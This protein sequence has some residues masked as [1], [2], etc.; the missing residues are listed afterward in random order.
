LDF[1]DIVNDINAV[2]TIV[3]KLLPDCGINADIR[4]SLSGFINYS[5]SSD[6]LADIEQ[7]VGAIAKISQDLNNKDFNSLITDALAFVNL[8]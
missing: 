2:L 3:E 4:D 8:A 5:N 1:P 7:I 6:C